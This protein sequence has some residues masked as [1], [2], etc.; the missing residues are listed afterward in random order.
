MLILAAYEALDPGDQWLKRIYREKYPEIFSDEAAGL[1]TLNKVYGRLE[2]HPDMLPGFE[3]WV[4][5]IW[6]S[7]AENLKHTKNPPKPLEAK[8]PPRMN[9]RPDIHA[10]MSAAWV[11]LHTVG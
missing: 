5:A 2:E 6:A 9:K 7:Y 3:K 1:E 11:R 10:G 4:A 8:R